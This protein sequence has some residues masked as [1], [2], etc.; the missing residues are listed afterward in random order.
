MPSIT[1]LAAAHTGSIDHIPGSPYTQV[2]SITYL[3]AAHTGSIDHI[4]GSPYTQV[5]SIT[6]L[7]AHTH[8][9]HRSHTWRQSIHKGAIDY[10]PGGSPYRQMPGRTK[11]RSVAKPRRM[12]AEFAACT[13]TPLL[14]NDQRQ[15]TSITTSD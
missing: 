3:A 2:P 5:P 10:I 4:P 7:A 12:A 1:Y 9:C 8:R 14:L 11:S 15:H 6:Y 13:L